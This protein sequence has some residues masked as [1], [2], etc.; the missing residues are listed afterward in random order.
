MLAPDRGE[1]SHRLPRSVRRRAAFGLG[2]VAAMWVVVVLA[3]PGGMMVSDAGSGTLRTSA[4]IPPWNPWICNPNNPSPAALDIPLANPTHSRSPGT[5]VTASYE[6]E[7]R[8]YVRADHGTTIY[9]PTAKAVLPTAPSGSL[10]VNFAPRNLTVLGKGWSAPIAGNFTLPTKTNF[11]TASA[12]LTTTKFAVLATAASGSLTLEFRWHWTILPAKGGAADVD[13]WS[14]P[15][16]NA[17]TPY[18]PSIFYPAPFVGLLASSGSPAAAGTNFTLDLDGTVSNTSFRVVLEYPNNGT[19]IQ[20][21]WENSSLG[22]T[23]F[24][25]TIPLAYRDGV[26][27][28]AGNYLVHVHDVCEAIVHMSPVAV[29]A[30]GAGA[31][32]AVTRP[33]FSSS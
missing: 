24:N 16:A 3:L 4:S 30:G 17:T 15:A 27:V 26:P 11:S 29:T 13:P 5:V 8:G 14:V 7:V 22:A 23:T 6:F 9:L 21:I 20:S 2:G 28:P 25:A 31:P 10:D 32:A 12:Y 33:G 18:L 1:D 19:E